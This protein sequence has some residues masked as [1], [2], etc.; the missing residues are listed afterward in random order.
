[1]EIQGKTGVESFFYYENNGNY[2]SKNVIWFK[3]LLMLYTLILKQ[4][5]VWLMGLFEIKDKGLL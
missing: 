2:S 3:I 5:L 4:F 1:M